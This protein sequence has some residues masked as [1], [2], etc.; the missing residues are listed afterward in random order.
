MFRYKPWN[1]TLQRK[2]VGWLSCNNRFALYRNHRVDQCDG[3]WN[4]RERSVFCHRTLFRSGSNASS[5][6][7]KP[8][9]ST[10]RSRRLLWWC[11]GLPCCPPLFCEPLLSPIF[12]EYQIVAFLRYP[13]VVILHWWAVIR[14][15]RVET[16]VSNFSRKIKKEWMEEASARSRVLEQNGEI[17]RKWYHH[18]GRY[19]ESLGSTQCGKSG[20]FSHTVWFSPVLRCIGE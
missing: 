7:P 16:R 8:P 10:V 15:V 19:K 2:Y 9:R 12:G 6:Q 17:I 4:R 14:S 3:I 5:S 13:S 18:S 1:K 20:A 11:D